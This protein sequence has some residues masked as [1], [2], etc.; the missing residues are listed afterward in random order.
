MDNLIA[1]YG[2]L[3]KGYGNYNNHASSVYLGERNQRK[4]SSI[5][6]G[7]ALYGKQKGVGHNVD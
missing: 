3:K 2:T 4:V 1:V 7:F 5:G 6:R